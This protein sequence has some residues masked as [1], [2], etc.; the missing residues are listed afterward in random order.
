VS[1]GRGEGAGP[2][3]HSPFPRGEPLAALC[4]L[5]LLASMFALEWFGVD[6][7]PAQTRSSVTSVDAWHGLALLSWLMLVT[8][9][10]TLG[11]AALHAG[12]RNHGT[13]T[14]TSLPLALLATLTTTLLVYRLLIDPPDPSSIVDLKLGALVGL[15]CALGLTL[16][17]WDAA[18]DARRPPAGPAHRARTG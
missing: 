6:L 11:S 3:P 9:I 5:A 15:A 18:R 10:S 17:A 14:N 1:T 7:N 16:F 2:A 4:A 8:I 12:Q 13:R